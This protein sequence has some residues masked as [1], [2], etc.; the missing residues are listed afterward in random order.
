MKKWS[1]LTSLVRLFS[2]VVQANQG[3]ERFN[4][5]MVKSV[6][7][8]KE[9][10]PFHGVES[11]PAETRLPGCEVGG[12][13]LLAHRQVAGCGLASAAGATALAGEPRL[14]RGRQTQPGVGT[15]LERTETGATRVPQR[16]A[17]RRSDRKGPAPLE[18]ALQ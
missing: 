2:G 4:V 6:V 13:G 9:G 14:R 11:R 17:P 8:G 5:Q 1:S 12:H 18:V 3:L 10:T 7:R 16:R 15:G